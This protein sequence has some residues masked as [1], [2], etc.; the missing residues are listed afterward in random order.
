[1]M[2]SILSA[3]FPGFPDVA[4]SLRPP[5]WMPGLHMRSTDVAG[6]SAS[7]ERGGTPRR[8]G[9]GP[10]QQR[11]CHR[12]S[13]RGMPHRIDAPRLECVV[14]SPLDAIPRT[15]SDFEREPGRERLV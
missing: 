13:C 4:L 14:T 10:V 3:S 11:G 1:M 5:S 15:F 8:S 2:T 12:R 7:Y 9:P 6:F